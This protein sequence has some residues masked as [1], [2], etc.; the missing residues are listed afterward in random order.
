IAAIGLVFFAALGTLFFLTFYLQ[1][2]RGFSPLQA[3]LLM[4]PFALAQVVFAPRS[5]AMVRRFGPRAVCAVG[6]SLV[7]I[8]LA[9]YAFVGVAAPVALLIALTFVQGMGMANVVPPATESIMSSLP[10]QRAGVGSAVSNTFR[11]VGGALGVAVLGAV[12]S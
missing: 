10:P 1:L 12:L 6:L 11:Q 8:A 3:G 7:T 9:G 4:T 5:A 2:V